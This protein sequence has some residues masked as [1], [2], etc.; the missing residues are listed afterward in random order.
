[1]EN[2]EKV[3]ELYDTLQS[4][5]EK[6]NH[7]L[8]WMGTDDMET[9]LVYRNSLASLEQQILEINEKILRYEGPTYRGSHI[10]LYLDQAY[11]R[12]TFFLYDVSLPKEFCCI[13]HVKISTKPLSVLGEAHIGYRLEK[14]YRGHHYMLEALELLRDSML[15]CGLKKPL[16]SVEPDNIA[17]IKTIEQFGGTLKF[18]EDDQR[19]Y[20]TYEVDLT[21]PVKQIKR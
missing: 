14:E 7:L 4:L 3:K 5:K 11:R 1:M 16:I 12:P 6:R 18:L 13:G 15:A 17:S 8:D 19:E 21:Q 20:R 2:E 9:F 10:D